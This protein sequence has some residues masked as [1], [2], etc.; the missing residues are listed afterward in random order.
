MATK[1]KKKAPSDYIAKSNSIEDWVHIA[2]FSSDIIGDGD[3]SVR[4][5]CGIE[6]DEESYSGDCQ[7]VEDIANLEDVDQSL[8]CP[9]CV[10]KN[11]IEELKKKLAEKE[12]GSEEVVTTIKPP[13][14]ETMTE[15]IPVSQAVGKAKTTFGDKV[16]SEFHQAKYRTIATQ[17]NKM[18][19]A[20]IKTAINASG[21]SKAQK[22]SMC[23]LLDTEMGATLVSMLA[24]TAVSLT[25]LE[26]NE[27]VARLASEI[28]IQAMS[29][30]GTAVIETFMAP[31]RDQITSLVSSLESIPEAI[32]A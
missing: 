11:E 22:A 27:K 16:L 24:G 23:S 7:V 13:V 3:N 4:T 26:N 12:S 20:G 30:G 10:A 14:K 19:L 31:I 21:L 5:L 9:A 32:P 8:K 29:G 18:A 28:R 6:V 1:K 2:L 15:K 17:V 25:P